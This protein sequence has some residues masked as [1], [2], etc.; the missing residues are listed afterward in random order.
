MFLQRQLVLGVLVLPALVRV[1]QRTLRCLP[2]T[3]EGFL[4]HLHHQRHVRTAGDGI[5]NN[6]AVPHVQ[7]RGKIPFDSVDDKLADVRGQFAERTRGC[8][9][10]VKHIG[11]L[12]TH[13]A[14]V[15]AVMALGRD[16]KKRHH[17]HQARYRLPVNH[18]TGNA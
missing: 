2:H 13:I 1:Q 4:E 5:T 15:G 9:L 6:L 10:P 8:K 12:L 14:L 11:C 16:A 7:Y 3:A 17:V 18:P